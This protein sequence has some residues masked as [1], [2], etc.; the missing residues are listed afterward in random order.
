MYQSIAQSKKHKLEES[1]LFCNNTF[2][3]GLS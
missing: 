3:K 1:E 2:K